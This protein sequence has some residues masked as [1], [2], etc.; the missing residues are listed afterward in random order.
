LK[1]R[2]HRQKVI[3]TGG[4]NRKDLLCDS[5]SR[6]FD[7]KSLKKT[8]NSAC[9]RHYPLHFLAL[10]H[11]YKHDG[12]LNGFNGKMAH[13]RKT[14]CLG[15]L[16]HVLPPQQ[17]VN[18]R[19]MSLRPISDW[20]RAVIKLL[21]NNNPAFAQ[22]QE[23]LLWVKQ[24][25]GLI[26]ELEHLNLVIN[27]IQQ[28]IKAN[29]VCKWT[30]RYCLKTVMKTCKKGKLLL[31]KQ[32]MKEYF[33]TVMGLV[34][35]EWTIACSSDIVESAFGKYKNYLQANPMVGFQI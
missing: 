34:K 19:F 3:G 4:T 35:D 25:R 27:R 21:D 24:Y 29:G 23:G 16:S 9:L 5:R 12:A 32:K 31:L 10:E 33:Q 30:V 18:A 2:G 15:K 13:M 20:G 1:S 8:I 22:E 28:V 7:K 17:R 6:Q 11:L 26:R 14:M